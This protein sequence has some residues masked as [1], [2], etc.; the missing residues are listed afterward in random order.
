MNDILKEFRVARRPGLKVA[1]KAAL[2]VEA[3]PRDRLLE[4]LE[5]VDVDA[6]AR[7]KARSAPIGGTGPLT[8]H[9]GV[10]AGPPDSLGSR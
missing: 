2:L 6:P 8:E 3:V 1:D 4:C 9:F 7:K 10:A 5:R